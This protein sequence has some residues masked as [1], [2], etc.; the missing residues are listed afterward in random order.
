LGKLAAGVAGLGLI[1]GAGTV[2]YNNHGD[3]TVKIKNEKT[4][5]VQSVRIEAG[6]KSFLCPLGMDDK[7]KPCDLAAGRIKLTLRQVRGEEHAILRQYPSHRGPRIGRAHILSEPS[8]SRKGRK[9]GWL[10][11]VQAGGS[12][13]H[14]CRAADANERSPLI[15]ERETRS[16]LGAG[17]CGWCASVTTRPTSCRR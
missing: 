10:V 11:S 8:S 15:G 7:L 16:R 17:R 14:A 12:R 1:G 13:R 6:G 5:R 2:V 4:G 3:A 9:T